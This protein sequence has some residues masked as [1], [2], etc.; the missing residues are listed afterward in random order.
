MITR[1]KAQLAAARVAAEAR[2]KAQGKFAKT[3]LRDNAFIQEK[4]RIEAANA[5]K[6]ARLRGLR[7]AKEAADRE[8][9]EKVAAE[10]AAR[11]KRAK[12]TP[13]PA[14]STA[15]NVGEAPHG[16]GAQTDIP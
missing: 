5:E 2:Q 13:A 4:K 7:L 1:E 16:D 14:A 8:I 15:E 6:T 10:K 12:A 3:Q 11:P 9:A